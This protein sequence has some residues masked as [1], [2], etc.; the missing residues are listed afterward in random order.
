M[1]RAYGNFIR[2][3]SANWIGRLGVAATTASF[4]LFLLFELASLLGIVTNAYVGLISY[5]TLPAAFVAG[6]VLVPLGWWRQMK[7]TGKSSTEL[8]QERFDRGDLERRRIGSQVFRVVLV[9]TAVNVL[10]LGAGSTQM[11][12][13]MDQAEFCGTACHVMAPEWAAYGDSPHANVDCVE[14]H[15]GEGVKGLY[16][17]KISGLRQTVLYVLGTHHKPVPTP[18]HQLSPADE[19]CL[20]CHSVPDRTEL[21]IRS[22]ARHDFDA[23]STPLYSTVAFDLGRRTDRPGPHWHAREDVEVRYASKDDARETVLWVEVREGDGPVRRF[24]YDGP[25]H[26]PAGDETPRVVDCVDC[27]N[28]VAHRFEPAER[29][30]D[31]LIT[32][33][34]L[35]RVLPEIKEVALAAITADYPDREAA[36]VGIARALRNAWHGEQRTVVTALQPE[37][38]R[39]IAALQATHARNVHPEMAIGWGTYPDHNGHA[40][41]GRGCF[42]CHN[43]DLVDETGTAIGSECTTCHAILAD[44]SAAPFSVLTERDEQGPDAETHRYLREHFEGLAVPVPPAL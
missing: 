14:C 18:V 8:L 12:H 36:Q 26:E 5:L 33:G 38:D 34:T 10:F 7:V 31:R 21:A 4:L 41:P 42:R 2:G 25:W 27:H 17:S 32:E 6:L 11:L 44:E 1:F 16:E 29:A 30:V 24:A 37:M 35:P 13:Y 20:H 9:L 28:R 40:A 39:A 43:P 22:R 3:V 19:T 15:V 23:E